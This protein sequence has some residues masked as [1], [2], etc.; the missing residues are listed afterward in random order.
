MKLSISSQPSSLCYICY[1]TSLA[2]SLLLLPHPNLESLF[3][4]QL[5]SNIEIQQCF[6]PG[7]RGEDKERNKKRRK[8]DLLKEGW[9]EV[10]LVE[11]EGVPPYIPLPQ[12][13]MGRLRG[14][15]STTHTSLQTSKLVG[16]KIHSYFSR[17]DKVKKRRRS[18]SMD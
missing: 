5:A 14:K 9:G 1:V 15:S 11:V 8:F 16:T 17:M 7:Q 3:S 4:P 13:R 12:R 10:Q 18:R 6:V 2:P